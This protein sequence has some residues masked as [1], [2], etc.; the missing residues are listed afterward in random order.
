MPGGGDSDA[1]NTACDA[2]ESRCAGH[3][4]RS[5]GTRCGHGDEGPCCGQP[6]RNPGN[7]YHGGQGPHAYRQDRSRHW[8]GA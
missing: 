1:D 2:H 4:N 5:R 7:T 8:R 3:A 6:N